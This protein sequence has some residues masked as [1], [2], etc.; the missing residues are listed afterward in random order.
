MSDAYKDWT[1]CAI[2]QTEKQERIE[3]QDLSAK[4]EAYAD[5]LQFEFYCT[6]SGM[7]EVIEFYCNDHQMTDGEAESTAVR[8]EIEQTAGINGGGLDHKLVS[9]LCWQMAQRTTFN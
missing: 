3:R 8:F 4:R 1:K 2:A 5:K 6:A 7:N 9:D